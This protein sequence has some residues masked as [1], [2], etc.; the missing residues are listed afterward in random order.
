MNYSNAKTPPVR[1]ERLRAGIAFGGSCARLRECAKADGGGCL[2]L[3]S[4]AF[5]QT[6]GCQFT[7]SLAI[8][9][10]LR[11]AV[12]IMHGPIGCGACS[13][14]GAG[15]SKTFKALRDP[16]SEGLI[17]LNTHLDEADVISG[18]EQKLKDAILYAEREFHPDS[19]IIPVSCV[20]SLIG[21]DV[22]AVVAELQEECAAQL[23][24]VHCPGFKTKVMATAYDDVYHGILRRIV[25]DSERGPD[26]QAVSDEHDGEHDN[27]HEDVQRTSA[28]NRTVNV[29]NVSSMSRADELELQRLLEAIGL[30]VRFLPCY[31]NGLDFKLALEGGLNVSIC[32]THD[33]YFL[34]HL[35]TLYDMPFILDTMPIGRKNTAR[36]LR[37]IAGH[38]N[39][40]EEAE[41]LIAAE[42]KALDEAL[43]PFRA[44][45]KG[46][47]VF[48]GGGEVRV[49][50]TAEII[51]DLDMEIV[52]FKGHHIDRF[53][54]PMWAQLEGVDS[55]TFNVATQQ[56]F[57]QANLIRRLKPDLL[58]CHSG[59]NN[60]AAKSGLPLLPLFGPTYQYMG[61]AGAFEVARRIKRLFVNSAFNRNLAMHCPLPYRQTWYDKDPFSYIK[62]S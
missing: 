12:I 1:E 40:S 6:Q 16:S 20:P 50:A 27:V 62:E 23:I 24:P 19:I 11:S 56:P 55:V 60:I 53:A 37:L 32:G 29:L 28:N 5:S 38:F 35:K 7:L 3:A 15:S 8:L 47:R 44:A 31:S 57:E 25:K 9:N 4:R 10:T 52:G 42:D 41:R 46:K 22:D 59:G 48:L 17:W 36:W 49:L 54:E 21:D 18:G 58:I 45:L 34:E 26:N 43:V 51:Q 39:V 61:Y 2:N 30:H 13:I 33:D 14:G